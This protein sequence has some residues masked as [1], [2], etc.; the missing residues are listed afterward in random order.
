M[1][2]FFLLT[3][4][5]KHLSDHKQLVIINLRTIPLSQILA[6]LIYGIAALIENEPD[7]QNDFTYLKNAGSIHP[8]LPVSLMVA[9]SFYSIYSAQSLS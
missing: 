4:L 1:T 5:K 9:T 8:L 6:E 7:L 2:T 3:I